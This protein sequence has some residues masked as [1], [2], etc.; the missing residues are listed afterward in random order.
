MSRRGLQLRVRL[1]QVLVQPCRIASGPWI[2]PGA[3]RA[4][5][6]DDRAGP[7][8]GT[9]SPGRAPRVSD[10]MAGS[11]PF[12]DAAPMDGLRISPPWVA[13][14]RLHV[15]CWP[16]SERS[17]PRACTSESWFRRGRLFQ[18]F[19]KGGL[20]TW[21][22]NVKSRQIALLSLPAGQFRSRTCRRAWLKVTIYMPDGTCARII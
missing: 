21:Q 7:T 5:R 8:E 6:F 15:H 10:C 12:R 11:P 2:L 22:E 4:L 3:G 17:Y 14:E 19:A 1:Q 13:G 18:G 9:P 20:S 16:R